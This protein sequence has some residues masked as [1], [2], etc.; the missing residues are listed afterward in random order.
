MAE[1]LCEKGIGEDRFLLVENGET[2]A[3]RM[4]VHGELRAGDR[5]EA[6]LIA[7]RAGSRR[8]TA[9]LPD[10]TEI[11]A[12]HLPRAATEGV[13]GIV[14]I[15]RAP[16]AER[17]RLKRAQGRWSEHD[18]DVPD[19]QAAANPCRVVRRFEAGAWEEVWH[20]AAASRIDF[21]GGSIECA[22]TPAMTLIDVD[23]D[24]SPLA[25]SRAAIPAIARA[26]RWFDIGG[27]VGIDFPSIE[28]KADRRAVDIALAEALADWSHESTAMN[29]FGF[30]QLVARL[31]GPS[32][33]HRFAHARI[34]TCARFALRL[35]ERVEGAGVTLLKVHPALGAHL[36]GEPLAELARRSGRETRV[37]IDPGVAPEAPNAQIIAR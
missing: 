27:S 13:S 6:Q 7:R 17:G 30:V 20:A 10:G 37:A 9:Q 5:R 11:L 1:W 12:D 8:G 34:A 31:E 16:I 2:I 21:A 14:R 24:D 29:G 36:R 4:E 35:A 28:A 23:G 22:T 33:L 26:L 15:T 19:P 18:R 32:L 25:L 3:A